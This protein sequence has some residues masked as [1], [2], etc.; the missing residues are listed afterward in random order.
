MITQGISQAKARWPHDDFAS[1]C[2]FYGD[3]RLK[4]WASQSLTRVRPPFPIYYES[5]PMPSGVL[6]HEKVA[7]AMLAA[8]TEI[9][10]RC[11]HDA[12][13]VDATGAS[14]YGGCF[15]IRPIAGSDN[16][17]NH[18][19]AAAI[20][21]APGKNGFRYTSSTTLDHLVI[22]AF[23]GQGALWGGDYRGRKDPMHFEFVSR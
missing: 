22:D 4:A 15:N 13:K 7:S 18:A 9:W 6:C 2:A 5:K 12:H 21:L 19:W 8:F 3:F 14:D 16:Y 17:S 23:K 20:D 1:K 10:D 11:G